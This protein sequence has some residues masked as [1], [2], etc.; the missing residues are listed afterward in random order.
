M[1]QLFFA[2]LLGL[3]LVDVATTLYAIKLGAHED[4]RMLMSQVLAIAGK[5][6]PQALVAAKLAFVGLIAWQYDAIAIWA[7][8][9][10]CAIYA[11]VIWNNWRVIKRLK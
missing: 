6:W 5:Y 1:K 9:A 4:G 7:F 8:A 10:M 3:Q 11:W 2:L